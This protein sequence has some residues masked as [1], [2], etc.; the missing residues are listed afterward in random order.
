MLLKKDLKERVINV[1]QNI[2]FKI[3]C[4]C[5]L[6]SNFSSRVYLGIVNEGFNLSYDDFE[7]F[8]DESMAELLFYNEEYL[9]EGLFHTLKNKLAQ[10]NLKRAEKK[11]DP[12]TGEGSFNLEKA[13]NA[14]ASAQKLVD[15]DAAKKE[16]KKKK[17]K[18]KKENGFFG[19]LKQTSQN[20]KKV[21]GDVADKSK[22]IVDN[23][24][25]TT[26]N[27]NNSTKNVSNKSKSIVDNIDS[28]TKNINNA[29][30][31]IAHMT[32]RARKATDKIN[33]KNLKKAGA[34]AA[35]VAAVGVAAKMAINS[36]DKKKYNAW[37]AESKDREYITIDKWRKLGRPSAK[38]DSSN[39][40][41]NKKGVSA[42]AE[43]YLEGYYEALYD[44][45]II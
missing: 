13:K 2:K 16:N 11:F 32:N 3:L 26:K 5:I 22:S 45:D 17:R 41:S 30:N 6:D 31:D 40:D 25:S 34:V 8:I 33:K 23:V 27:V 7:N 36:V 12:K 18:E 35:G 29:T 24:D 9:D 14:A 15:A 28:T 38:G 20:V 37:K 43:A 1:N 39:E 42:K 4:E 44:M 21:T 10:N 19:G